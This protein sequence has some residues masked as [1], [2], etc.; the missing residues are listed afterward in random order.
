MFEERLQ[1]A[2]R[3][4]ILFAGKFVIGQLHR[5]LLL[6]GSRA[7]DPR[8]LFAVATATLLAATVLM[9]LT[10]LAALRWAPRSPFTRQTRTLRLTFLLLRPLISPTLRRVSAGS[11]FALLLFAFGPARSTF[12][13][14][15]ARWTRP[16]RIDHGKRHPPSLHVHVENPGRDNVSDTDDVVWA[17]NESIG[18]F[19][20][21]NEAAVLEADIDED[22]KVDHVEDRSLQLHAGLQIFNSKDAR[23]EDR[24]GKVF[25]RIATGTDE[26][27]ED[28]VNRR[29]TGGELF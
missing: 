4:E 23:S 11:L 7:D 2:E 24:F 21:V 28:V 3:V 16:S 6:L 1:L 18:D 20:D 12:A 17:A 22:P 27:I 25:A 10:M 8:F 26:I 29:N 5:R 15:T 14:R 13:S 9:L 19:A